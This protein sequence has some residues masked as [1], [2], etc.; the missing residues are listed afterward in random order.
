MSSE[1]P[2][3]RNKFGVVLLEVRV[4]IMM[5][6]ST[7]PVV[8]FFKDWVGFLEAVQVELTDEAREVGRF[9][10]VSVVRAGGSQREDL[11]L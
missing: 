4:V 1:S 10:S 9:E 11:F 6:H 2:Q 5:V 8:L 3:T 7:V